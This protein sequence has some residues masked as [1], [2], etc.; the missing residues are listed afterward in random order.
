[1]E[2]RT[3]VDRIVSLLKEG[4]TRYVRGKHESHL[5]HEENRLKT[6]NEGQRPAVA[7]L[8]CSDSRV[9][10][11]VLFDC[12][13]GDIFTVR[14]AGNVAGSSESGSL[15]YAADHLGISVLLVMGHTQCGAVTAAVNGQGS[16]GGVG[17]ILSKIV[18]AVNKTR[19]AYPGLSG[20]ELVE[21]VVR[22]NVWQTIEE[23]LNTSPA[24][25]ESVRTGRLEILGACYDIRDGRIEWMGIHPKQ[26]QLLGQTT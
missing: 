26:E 11:E 22:A 25:R 17:H 5:R 13:I 6:S 8:S 4:N 20:N 15:E 12:S 14:V 18:P 2:H 21:A 1:M 10:V 9:P 24:I 23:L 7:V 16:G 3:S 19:A